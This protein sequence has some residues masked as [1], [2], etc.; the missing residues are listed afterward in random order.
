MSK[1]NN[2][3]QNSSKTEKFLMIIVSIIVVSTILSFI[4]K[5]IIDVHEKESYKIGVVV[6]SNEKLAQAMLNGIDTYIQKI[7][8]DKT[9][10]YNYQM[11][12]IKDDEKDLITKLNQLSTS[13]NIVGIIGFYNNQNLIDSIQNI[14]FPIYTLTK[15]SNDTNLNINSLIQ[16]ETQKAQFIANYMRN[17]KK[18]HFSYF[19]HDNSSKCENELKEFENLYN[20]FEIPLKG[21]VSLKDDITNYFKKVSIGAVYVCGDE[22]SSLNILKK[23]QDSKTELNIYTNQNMALNSVKNSQKNSAD[24][25]DGI[26]VATPLLFDTSTQEAQTFLNNYKKLYKED[27]DWLGAIFYDMAKIAFEKKLFL[28]QS[29][30]GVIKDY[31]MSEN[32]TDIAI[33]MGQFNGDQLIS[34]PIQLQA[35]KNKHSIGNYI[36]AL[37]DGRVLYVNDKF[38]YKTNVVYT[39]IKVN[40]IG[41]IKEDEE[42]VE[43]DFSIWFRYQGDFDPSETIFLNSDIELKNPEEKIDM[44]NDHYVRFRSKGIFKMNFEDSK[45]SYGTNTINILYRHK[46]LNHNN[47]I[48]VTDVLGMAPNDEIL[49]QM[50]ERKVLDGNLGWNINDFA[51]SQY[52]NKDFSE[53]KPQYIGYQGEESLFSTVNISLKIESSMLNAKDFIDKK[54]FIYLMILGLVGLISA[55]LMDLKKLGRY[56]YFHSFILRTIFLPI[57]IISAGNLLLD[58]AYVNIDYIITGYLVIVYES[59]WWIAP[60]Y[61]INTGIKRFVWNQ[62]EEKA[63]R[64]IPA[65]VMILSSFSIYSLALSGMIAFVFHQELTSILAA[66]GVIAMVVGLAIEANIANVFSGLILNMDK[67]FK[68]GERIEFDDIC[69]E[70]VDISWRTTKIKQWDGAIF[71]IPNDTISN[72]QIKNISRTEVFLIEKNIDIS[73]NIDPV[74]VVELLNEA[75]FNCETLVKKDD[76]YYGCQAF[77]AGYHSIGAGKWAGNYLLCFSIEDYYELEVNEDEIWTNIY[78]VFQK[79]GLNVF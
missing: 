51:I 63:G 21:I 43:V 16:N 64:K 35:I 71:T 32:R 5:E 28:N 39:G 23:I 47:L 14:N 30:N 1:L 50:Q 45:K 20:R 26:F 65:I 34:A 74:K 15:P 42:S 53:G 19:V 36:Q 55:R 54:Y 52:L 27:P 6:P 57:F 69:G 61:L 31:D 37:R 75:L 11:E 67:L 78:S 68:V 66:S 22:N 79:E 29:I 12:V 24:I 4:V 38:M 10:Q 40:S 7:N 56:W 2:V 58:W 49:Q 48:F 44:E 25:L 62:L 3:V 59:I 17:V 73:A 72:T 8:K 13:E 46:K 70:V 41:N 9:S 60:A 76:E 18:E 33:K 77:F